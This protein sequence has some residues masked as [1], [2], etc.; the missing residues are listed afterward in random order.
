[1]SE[2]VRRRWAAALAERRVTQE[3]WWE[4]PESGT[5][6]DLDV[7][8]VVYAPDGDGPA[9][10]YL[11]L[12]T[13]APDAPRWD[14]SAEAPLLEA[15]LTLLDRVRAG[16]PD[17]FLSRDPASGQALAVVRFWTLPP[18]LPEPIG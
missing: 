17:V 6:Y 5:R 13:V 18:E 3:S 12:P 1:M 11:R 14:Y 9:R 8:V 15:V 4:L 16:D 7:M 10:A 2:D